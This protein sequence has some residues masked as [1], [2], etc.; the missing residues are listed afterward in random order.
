MF[1]LARDRT[2]SALMV[3]MALMGVLSLMM[4]LLMEKI[5]P[6]S[7]AT[8]GIE[9]SAVALYRSA[10]MIEKAFA[11][12]NYKKP[13]EATG[14]GTQSWASGSGTYS[15][16]Q[17]SAIIPIPGKGN[18]E[19]DSN[20]NRINAGNPIQLKIKPLSQDNLKLLL[21]EMVI[22]LR[23]PKLGSSDL[24]AGDSIATQFFTG[25]AAYSVLTV[26]LSNSA[27]TTLTAH[28]GTGC[29]PDLAALKN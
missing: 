4:I 2:G 17:N 10:S 12:M 8:K 11:T 26:S 24:K 16:T 23:M 25:S 1:Q 22:D 6:A 3:S 13:G 29:A 28:Y 7:Q 20:W 21:L 5:I 15:I 27:G 14:N 18:S 19:Y 9:H